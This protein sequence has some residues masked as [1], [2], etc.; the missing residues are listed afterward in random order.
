MRFLKG[1]IGI[2]QGGPCG[3]GG[4]C[5]LCDPGESGDLGGPGG[6]GGPVVTVSLDDMASENVW[7]SE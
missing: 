4:P 1:K 7:F 5:D 3:P 6:Q 2:G